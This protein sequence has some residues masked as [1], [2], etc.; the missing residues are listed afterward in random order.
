MSTVIFETKKAIFHF[1][2]QDISASLQDH[3]SCDQDATDLVSILES[4]SSET[5]RIPGEK[6]FFGY[7]VVDLLGKD[8]GFVFCKDCQK[9]YLAE[10]LQSI[11]TGFGESPLT[12]KLFRKGG[13]LRKIFGRKTKRV[14]MMGGKRFE[15]PKGHELIAMITW[16][17]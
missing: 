1:D 3:S 4:S 10:E 13:I 17:S 2:L 6:G 16:I 5:R 14:G 12:V 15:C 8:K 11:P 7:I 9:T